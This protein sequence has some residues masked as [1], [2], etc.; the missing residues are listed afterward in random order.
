MSTSIESRIKEAEKRINELKRTESSN[1]YV[2][3]TNKN[4]VLP[5]A[6]KETSSKSRVLKIRIVSLSAQDDDLMISINGVKIF[7]TQLAADQ[8]Y[9]K[10]KD[11]E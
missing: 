6:V 9:R 5:D 1:G 11:L 8:Y 4:V 10:L 7:D 3:I 2:S